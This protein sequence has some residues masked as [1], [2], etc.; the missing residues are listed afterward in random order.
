MPRSERLGRH[1]CDID[2]QVKGHESADA[3]ETTKGTM[4]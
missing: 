4:G 1:N 3:E 2:Y